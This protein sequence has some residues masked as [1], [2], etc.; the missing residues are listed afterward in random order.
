MEFLLKILLYINISLLILHEMDAIKCK[1]WNMF[2]ILKDLKENIAYLI[3][4]I[5]HL[6]IYFALIYIIT[7]G[8]SDVKF[9]IGIY[10]SVFLIFHWLIHFAFKNKPQNNFRNLYSSILINSMGFCSLV[11]IILQF[12]Y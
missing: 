9:R 3:F 1:E 4:S 2:I 12:M 6:P 5:M 8:S 7:T 10:I 11:Y